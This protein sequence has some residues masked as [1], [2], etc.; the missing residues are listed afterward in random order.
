MTPR[1]AALLVTSAAVLL[2]VTG[3]SGRILPMTDYVDTPEERIADFSGTL[4]AEVA[5]D[6][7]E[8]GT[9]YWRYRAWNNWT[10]QYRPTP[11][12]WVNTNPVPWTCPEN[13]ASGVRLKRQLYHLAHETS[14]QYEL[15]GSVV[16]VISNAC[17]AKDSNPHPP[18]QAAPPVTGNVFT[19]FPAQLCFGTTDSP[20]GGFEAGADLNKDG[21]CEP[22]G[23]WAPGS[24]FKPYAGLGYPDF[25]CE[26]YPYADATLPL[27]PNAFGYI[28]CN[29]PGPG[30]NEPPFTCP[31][32]TPGDYDPAADPGQSWV[33]T[34]D[35]DYVMP[36]Q[37]GA[38]TDFYCGYT[39]QTRLIKGLAGWVR[40]RS[41]MKQDLCW[42]TGHNRGSYKNIQQPYTTQDITNYGKVGGWQADGVVGGVG[43]QVENGKVL[44]MRN[45]QYHTCFPPESV[46][47]FGICFDRHE[48]FHHIKFLIWVNQDNVAMVRK[49]GNLYD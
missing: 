45:L 12:A 48:Y 23:T 40:A 2:V 34:P 31:P 49:T 33:N 19:T 6:P 42:G 30:C 5:C 32:F 16:G 18:S 24:T 1:R 4:E 36:R 47:T 20:R 22:P 8:S 35:G 38:G 26:V 11:E 41:Y 43:P 9:L 46:I 15:C 29:G 44:V 17:V 3:C 21:Y 7:G 37:Y 10:N 25:N 27:D 13:G 14:Y 39:N 28:A